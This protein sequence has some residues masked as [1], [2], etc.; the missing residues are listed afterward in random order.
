MSVIREAVRKA[1]SKSRKKLNQGE[2]EKSLSQKLSAPRIAVKTAIRDLVADRELAYTYHYGCSFLEKSFNKPTRISS[3]VVLKPPDIQYKAGSDDIV[4]NIQPGAAFGSGEHPTTRLAVRGIEQVLSRSEFFQDK[5]DLHG[6]DIGTG[7]GVL[8][9]VAAMLGIRQVVGLDIDPCARAEALK[10]VH[11]N[12]LDNRIEIHDRNAENIN[13]KFA[14]ITANL[15]YPTLKRLCPLLAKITETGG[16]V[17]VSGVKADEVFNLLQMFN[18]M[19]FKCTWKEFE[20]DWAGLVVD[21]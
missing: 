10:N 2:L 17:I 14:L 11:L 5:K 8:A 3:R 1:V 13:T 7:S 15:R 19:N 18:E 21:R 9:I 20:E 4:V 12:N 6:L 16:A